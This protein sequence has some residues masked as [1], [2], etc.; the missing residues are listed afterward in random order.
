MTHKTALT[1]RSVT[2]IVLDKQKHV[3]AIRTVPANTLVNVV[4]KR[5]EITI[6]LPHTLFEQTVSI[7]TLVVP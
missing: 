5:G 6:R 3:T 4:V 2:M 7:D 1:S